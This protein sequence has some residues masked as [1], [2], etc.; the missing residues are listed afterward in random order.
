MLLS[1]GGAAAMTLFANRPALAANSSAS[2]TLPA[3]SEAGY[4]VYQPGKDATPMLRAGVMQQPPYS[5]NLAGDFSPDRIPNPE[6]GGFCAPSAFN[7]D[8][9]PI[10]ASLTIWF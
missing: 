6:T 3:A 5:F 9:L 7:D 8:I 10:A 4:Y 1:V 2:A